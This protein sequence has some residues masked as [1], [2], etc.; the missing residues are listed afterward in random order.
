MKRISLLSMCGVFVAGLLSCQPAAT[1]PVATENKPAASPATK[2]AADAA[3]EREQNSA[4]RR[5]RLPETKRANRRSWQRPISD[6]VAR[7]TLRRN[8]RYFGKD[9]LGCRQC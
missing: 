9:F 7:E 3:G 4:A 6:R 2:S 1:P 5:R 8:D